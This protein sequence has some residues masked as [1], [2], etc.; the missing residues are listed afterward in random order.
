MQSNSSSRTGQPCNLVH[1]H[2]LV[3]CGAQAFCVAE[4]GAISGMIAGTGNAYTVA[5]V[6]P[7]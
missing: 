6:D 5:S 4:F 2:V 7:K 1:R 3:T